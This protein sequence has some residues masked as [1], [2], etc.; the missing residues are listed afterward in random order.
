MKGI[1]MWPYTPGTNESPLPATP[2]DKNA[3]PLPPRF[4]VSIKR[5]VRPSSRGACLTAGYIPPAPYEIVFAVRVEVGSM[6]PMFVY[7]ALE[8]RPTAS[9]MD[10]EVGLAWPLATMNA[11]LG[12]VVRGLSPSVPLV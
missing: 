11:C 12:A 2:T 7:G 5:R 4:G 1:Q 6:L 9:T 10:D 8:R 3:W